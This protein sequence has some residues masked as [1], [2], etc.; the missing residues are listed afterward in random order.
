MIYIIIF[1]LLLAVLIENQL[2]KWVNFIR[3]RYDK[4]YSWPK[5]NIITNIITE[6][7]DKNPT[8]TKEEFFI[9]SLYLYDGLLG[10]NNKPNTHNNE[11]RYEKKKRDFNKILYR[12]DWKKRKKRSI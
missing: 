9:H 7:L 6:N 10:T 3:F 5:K 12:Q 1:A 8:Y 11:I 4:S 2:Q